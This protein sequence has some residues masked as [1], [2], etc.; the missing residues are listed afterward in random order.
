MPLTAVLLLVSDTPVASKYVNEQKEGCYLFLLL[1]RFS[2][3]VTEAT[4]K[5]SQVQGQKEEDEAL[6][7]NSSRFVKPMLIMGDPKYLIPVSKIILQR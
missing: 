4:V 7:S 3:H 6:G 2:S 5:P 1:P